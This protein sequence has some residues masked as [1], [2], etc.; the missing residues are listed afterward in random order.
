MIVLGTQ[1][2]LIPAE[3]LLQTDELKEIAIYCLRRSDTWCWSKI[4]SSAGVKKKTFII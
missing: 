2:A 1:V 4:P 3:A